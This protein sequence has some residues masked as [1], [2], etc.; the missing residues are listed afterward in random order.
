MLYNLHIRIDPANKSAEITPYD[1]PFV[2]NFAHVGFKPRH[3]WNAVFS[4]AEVEGLFL[5][6]ITCAW[7]TIYPKKMKRQQQQLQKQQG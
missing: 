3:I 4:F 5:W 7:E 2:I 1:E 6:V